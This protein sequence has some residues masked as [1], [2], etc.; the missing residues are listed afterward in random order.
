[1]K[2]LSSIILALV[3]IAIVQFSTEAQISSASD[4]LIAEPV[5]QR[6]VVF[7]TSDPGVSK[8]IFWGLDTA[9]PSESNILRGIAFMGAER[10]DLVRASFQP[11][12]PL[13]N[14][15]L[16][17]DQINSLNFRLY[18][19]DLVGPHAKVALNCDHPSVD[20]WYSG[21]AARWAQLMDV[22]TRRVQETG[23][24]VVS[25]APFNE[26]DFGWGQGTMQ[27]FY[28]IAGELK[29]NPRFSDIRISGG[30]TLSCDQAWPWYNFLKGRL[31][32]GN[33]HQLA[34]SFDSFADFF[35]SVRSNG[36]YASDDELHNVGEA[37][38]GVEY[39][40]Q[41]GIWWGTAELA[42]GEFVKASDGVRLGYAEHRPNWTAAS[43]YRSPEGKIQ[44]F[45]GTSERQAV[46]TTYRFFSKDHDVFFDGQGPKR[47]YTM[48]LPG[49]TGYQTG[50]TNAERVVNIT[51]GDDIQPF[52][53]GRYA[54]VNRSTGK[55]I[56]IAGASANRGVNLQPGSY[57]SALHQMW[58]VN[59]VDSRVG[60]DFSYYAITSAHSGKAAD[61]LNWSLDDATN[62][63]VWDDT[64][65]ANQQWYFQYVEDGWFH[66]RSRHSAK[67]LNV[68][69]DGSTIIQSDVNG[70]AEQQWRFLPVDAEVE[71]VEPTAPTDLTL[72]AN[73][74]SVRLNWTA[75]AAHDVAGYTIFRSESAGGPYNTIARNVVT[76][77]YVDNT[78]TSG[79]P[80]YYVI[81]AVDKSLNRSSYSNEISGT[82]TGG[83]DMIAH[84]AF[85]SNTKDG[86]QNLNHAAAYEGIMFG[87][88]RV[89]TGAVTFDGLYDFIQLPANIAS[90][91]A[92]TIATWVYWE[93]GSNWQ[94]IFDFGNGESETMFL[95]PSSSSGKMR[96]SIKNNGEEQ[97]LD[98]PALAKNRWTHV[99]VILD[100]TGVKLYLDGDIAAE[101]SDITFRPLD[102]KPALN[103][104]GR[105]QYSDPL[106]DGRIDDFR[107]YN[108]A[109]PP[110]VIAELAAIEPDPTTSVVQESESNKWEVWPLPA[111]EAVRVR[112]KT[113]GN[114]AA[115]ISLHN[116]NG[117]MLIEK[118]LVGNVDTELN[119]AA[120][121]A[122]VYI[123]KINTGK[124]YVSKKIIVYR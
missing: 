42:R 99:A 105:S 34:G 96:F 75:S 65:G 115:T 44:A 114:G 69:A 113:P 14:D 88:G 47:E 116:V 64:K 52:I 37:M 79:G 16:Q 93:G 7:K 8:P 86:S 98:I 68:S 97:V 57:A 120:V 56:E 101:N 104:I 61:V 122:G 87:V 80:Y 73:P 23:R 60:G 70:Q 81:R 35:T 107:I 94:R 111:T 74:G 59:P 12:M 121:P 84:Y 54:L 48:V 26:P 19:I 124:E 112:T 82:P 21:N 10:V 71:F 15:D 24:T 83:E 89:G 38:V 102:F 11:T 17:A 28:N 118:Y 109:L 20:P 119:V 32:E 100:E 33:T 91:Q 103:Y 6:T 51:W 45:G 39:G 29:N 62:I 77:S 40:M 43:V 55:V 53:K 25:I 4:Y 1:V 2:N 123:L 76:T 31:D 5:P 50:Q 92:M 41:T 36:H 78:V 9:W 46:T 22:T 117:T 13:V 3:F 58:D 108:Y 106:Y 63:I 85:D 95:T 49:G 90:H 18:L 27:D 66:I 72:T 30:N 110:T 67:C